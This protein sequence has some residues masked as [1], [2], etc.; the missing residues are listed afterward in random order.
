MNIL[1]LYTEI[2]AYTEACFKELATRAKI[3]VVKY[4]INKEAP[5]QFSTMDNCTYYDR[6]Q[7][8]FS[9]LLELSKNISPQLLIVSGWI[10]KD[11]IKIA[12]HFRGKIPVV[13]TMDN[14]WLGTAKQQIL[15]LISPFYLKRIFSY[16]W[17]PGKPQIEYAK[18]L[19]FREQQIKIG[20]YSA[21]VN[22][23]N[24]FHELFK[25]KKAENFP[26][27]FLYVGR[28]VAFKNMQL[29]CEAFIEAV[30]E[31]QSDWELWCI[32]TG[33]L[34]DNRIEHPQIKHI[35]F[36][37][38]D[39]M[40][41]Y[42]EQSGVFV[43]PS[44]VEN[45]GVVVHEFAAAGFPLICST[46]VGAASEFLQ[47][48]QNGFT[49]NPQKKAGLKDIFIRVM[50]MRTEELNCMGRISHELAQKVTPE[51]W[52]DTILTFN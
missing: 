43:L 31:K 51:I 21:N 26:K 49:F 33:E 42:V 30:V 3:Y 44:V 39:D 14:Y 19:G 13:L 2:A 16:I 1:F 29:M 11:Y 10:D 28:Y 15:R 12:K 5:F 48:G 41:E 40:K 50:D 34:W 6:S 36:V 7:Y 4:P 9:D 46:G 37:Q 47:D 32:G 18:K 23:Y 45:W 17:V 25:E 24:R 52:A 35:G 27:C 22:Y 8:T 38:P 20:F